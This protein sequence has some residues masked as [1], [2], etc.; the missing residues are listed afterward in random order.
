MKNIL[1]LLLTTI[2]FLAAACDKEDDLQCDRTSTNHDILCC[3]I[4]GEDW[5]PGG[6]GPDIISPYTLEYYS[7]DDFLKLIAGNNSNSNFDGAIVIHSQNIS[8][9]EGK[10]TENDSN[11]YIQDDDNVNGC[12]YYGDLDSDFE[13]YIF[14][15]EIDSLNYFMKGEFQFTA[16]NDCQDTIRVTEGYFD[17]NYFF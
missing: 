6:G 2:L 5:K 16:I 12:V 10:I 17:L 7:D 8:L 11:F 4:N 3:K 9:G 15:T 14:V 13:N 1:F